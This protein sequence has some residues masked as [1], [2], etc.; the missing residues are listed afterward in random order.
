MGLVVTWLRIVPP[1]PVVWHRDT[2]GTQS[3]DPGIYSR[4]SPD[5]NEWLPMS[6]RARFQFFRQHFHRVGK[7]VNLLLVFAQSKVPCFHKTPVQNVEHS[8][9]D[10]IGWAT[11]DLPHCKTT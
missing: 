10:I 5:S 1:G 2:L 8:S 6:R 4:T 9:H 11:H 3:I 7:I